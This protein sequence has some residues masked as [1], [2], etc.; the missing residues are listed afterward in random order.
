M[1]L[2]GNTRTPPHL[3]GRLRALRALEIRGAVEPIASVDDDTRLVRPQLRL[4]A[5]EG[6]RERRHHGPGRRFVD[7]EI[8]VVTL[9]VPAPAAVAREPRQVAR[10][11]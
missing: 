9:A 6:A 1:R 4:D 10:V 11:A 2:N 5:R 7:E 3:G 8:P